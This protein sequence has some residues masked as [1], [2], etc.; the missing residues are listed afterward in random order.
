MTG[1]DLN[2]HVPHAARV[3]D[4]ILGGKD[5]FAA[6]RTVAARMVEAGGELLPTSMRANRRFMARVGRFLATEQ[7][8]RQ[9]LDIGT[10]IPT[11][12][13]LHQVIQAEIPDANIL[14]VDNDPLVLVHARA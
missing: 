3:Y 4:Y 11:R 1:D 5:N 10:G 6:D 12:P 7:G 2:T 13:N 14:Y 8:I 9:F